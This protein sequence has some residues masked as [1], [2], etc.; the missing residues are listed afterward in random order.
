MGAGRGWTRAGWEQGGAGLGQGGSREVLGQGGSRE[1][2][3]Y[4]RVG[5]GRGWTRAGWEQGGAW[6]GWAWARA[7]KEWVRSNMTKSI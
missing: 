4:G 5:A 2:L 1:G 3:D 7:G 6:A